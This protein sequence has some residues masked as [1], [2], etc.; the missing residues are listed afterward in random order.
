MSIK[1]GEK[2]TLTQSGIK[3]L[4]GN[5]DAWC[6]LENMDG[7]FIVNFS[8]LVV[9][10]VTGSGT[11]YY[12][13]LDRSNTVAERC[14]GH[15]IREEDLVPFGIPTTNNKTIMS[16][17]KSLLKKVTRTEPEKTFVE[18]GFMDENGDVTPSGQEALTHII[19][20]E[21]ETELKAL[22]DQIKEASN[23]S[24]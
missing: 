4:A 21:K 5:C 24:K 7:G 13:I 3:K 2:Y 16:S 6:R 20:K 22:A 18:V 11:V 15:G 14:S 23:D 1:I 12:T 9:T 17:F 19:W 10:D 8:H